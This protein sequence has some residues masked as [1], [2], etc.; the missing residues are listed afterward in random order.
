MM[1]ASV[2]KGTN[3]RQK[4]TG[5]ESK[6]GQNWGSSNQ[7]KEIINGEYVEKRNKT[8]GDGR[9]LRIKDV[10]TSR[11][12][13]SKNINGIRSVNRASHN[14][15]IRNTIQPASVN[16]AFKANGTSRNCTKDK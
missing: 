9:G 12:N 5:P 1:A 3:E 13:I 6:N 14:G 10:E 8:M 4:N 7:D 15:D 2:N 16:Y 11:G